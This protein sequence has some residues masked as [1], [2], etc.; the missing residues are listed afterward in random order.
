MDAEEED[1]QHVTDMV[2]GNNVSHYWED[3]GIIGNRF[4][5]TLKIGVYAWDVWM[6]YKPGKLWN[7]EL[8]PA[9]DF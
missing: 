9:P 5:D 4:Q 6:I 3:S 7:D 8:P 1:V 2:S